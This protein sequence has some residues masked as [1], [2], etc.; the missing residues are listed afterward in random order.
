M[1]CEIKDSELIILALSVGHLREIGERVRMGGRGVPFFKGVPVRPTP[2]TI[3][4]EIEGLLSSK[5]T[6]EV[7]GFTIQ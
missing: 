4:R 7:R 6:L 1:I 3:R 2:L 5:Q